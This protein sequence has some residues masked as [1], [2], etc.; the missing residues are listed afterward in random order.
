MSAFSWPV[1]GPILFV[2]M[3]VFHTE[4]IQ[5]MLA[6]PFGQTLLLAAVVLEVIGLVWTLRLMKPVY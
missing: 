1:S 5:Q 6:S 3:Y 2:Y 4:Y